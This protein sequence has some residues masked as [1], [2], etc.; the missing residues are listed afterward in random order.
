VIYLDSSVVLADLFDERHTIP[1][2]FWREELVSSRLLEYEVWNR[3][4][5]REL[6]QAKSERTN[7]LINH[8][9]FIEMTPAVLSRALQPFSITLRTLDSLH[10]ATLAHVYAR[11]QSTVLASYD[12]R[13]VAG[14]QALNIPLYE[15]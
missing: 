10:V 11:D 2:S 8:I 3:I 6:A 14:A 15:F 4:H 5:S 9:N 7:V 1:V 12:K 13:M